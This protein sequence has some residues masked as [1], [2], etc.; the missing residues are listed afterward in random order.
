M[1]KRK[2]LKE[3]EQDY[4]LK[5]GH[6]YYTDVRKPHAVENLSDVDRIHLVID[7]RCNEHFRKWLVDSSKKYPQPKE[8]DDYNE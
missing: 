6:F 2:I 7:I 3:V 1:L 8:V 5:T 4:K